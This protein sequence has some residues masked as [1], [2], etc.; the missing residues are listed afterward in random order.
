MKDGTG[1]VMRVLMFRW[2]GVLVCNTFMDT[3]LETEDVVELKENSEGKQL[4][5]IMTCC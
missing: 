4:Q 2:T 1:F 5:V 3:A